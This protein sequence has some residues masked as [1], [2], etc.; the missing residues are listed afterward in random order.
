ML[1]QNIFWSGPWMSATRNQIADWL[2]QTASNF[3]LPLRTK[4]IIETQ[5]ASLD[6]FYKDS[7][8]STAVN[9][10]HGSNGAFKMADQKIYQA[11][12][13]APVNIAVVK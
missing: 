9:H 1:S 11:S 4:Q 6:N 12:T 10:I 8:T 2:A 7:I 3:H 5:Q 13:T